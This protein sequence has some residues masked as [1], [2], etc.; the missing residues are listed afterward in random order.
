MLAALSLAALISGF[1]SDPSPADEVRRAGSSNA[2]PSQTPSARRQRSANASRGG[3]SLVDVEIGKKAHVQQ[4]RIE[5]PATKPVLPQLPTEAPK[6]HDKAPR[7]GEQ[8]KLGVVVDKAPTHTG[9]TSN[10]RSVLLD[11]VKGARDDGSLTADQRKFLKSAYKE[12]ANSTSLPDHLAMRDMAREHGALAAFDEI[13]KAHADVLAPQLLD[14][15][16]VFAGAAA[17][18]DAQGVA[19]ALGKRPEFDRAVR[20]ELV[21]AFGWAKNDHER[22]EVNELAQRLG[23][24][25]AEAPDPNA[26]TYEASP[27]HHASTVQGGFVSPAPSDGQLTL[28]ASVQVKPESPRRV[29]VDKVAQEYVVF[30]ET[31]PG[32]FHGHT[33]TW[34]QLHP[35]M[36]RSL[37]ASGAVTNNGRIL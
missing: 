25:L 36:Q 28:E 17:L 35:D 27:K 6:A 2:N 37:V 5:A 33:R 34:D 9:G 3:D 31:V 32:T 23:I 29:G 13:M 11:H 15:A 10:A 30:D 14:G 26:R 21:L 20:E 22:G 18:I 8:R 7:D 24:S 16:H 12:L 1:A 19:G 4:R